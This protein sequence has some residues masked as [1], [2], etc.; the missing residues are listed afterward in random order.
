M[1][2]MLRDCSLRPIDS[3]AIK[4]GIWVLMY[5]RLGTIFFLI[6]KDFDL[7]RNTIYEKHYFHFDCSIIHMGTIYQTPLKRRKWIE[8]VLG[9]FS[10]E[11]LAIAKLH[12]DKTM[13]IKQ[14]T[15]NNAYNNRCMKKWTPTCLPQTP[16]S[17]TSMV[18]VVH[19]VNRVNCY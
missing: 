17:A 19:F 5:Q 1:R 6:S 4:W 10:K 18:R 16:L 14:L 2:S 9:F 15:L 13:K 8:N 11:K 7:T 3:W 12:W